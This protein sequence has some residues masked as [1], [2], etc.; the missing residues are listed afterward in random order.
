M[1]L[2]VKEDVISVVRAKMGS[3]RVLTKH[4]QQTHKRARGKRFVFF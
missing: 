2:A 3:V 4:E 1:A